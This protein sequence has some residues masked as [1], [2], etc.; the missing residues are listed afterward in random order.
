MTKPSTSLVDARTISSVLV[1]VLCLAFA[2]LSRHELY[3]KTPDYALGR[4]ITSFDNG[5]EAGFSSLYTT[6]KSPATSSMTW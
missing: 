5:D 1:I 4:V 2:V 6:G 3:E